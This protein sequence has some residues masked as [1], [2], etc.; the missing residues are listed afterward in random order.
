MT[1][2]FRRERR[3]RVTATFDPVEAALL[4]DLTGQLVELVEEGVPTETADPL[5]VALGIGPGTPPED[6]V[7]A[8]L[9]PDAYTAPGTE[10]DPS[11]VEDGTE[12]RRYTEVGLRQL[13]GNRA[14]GVR[15]ELAGDPTETVDVRLDEDRAAQWLTVLTD[16]RLA[17]AAR[18]GLRTEA[19]AAELDA[20]ADRAMADPGGLDDA[21]REDPRLGVHQVYSWL[22]YLQE[23]LVRAMP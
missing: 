18:I 22:G 7:L 12:F 17:L 1:A 20:A 14:R 2:R 13:K 5:A 16:L 3:R 9:L 11:Q 21:A 23:T 4:R 15:D 8:R 19:D 6:P 10:P